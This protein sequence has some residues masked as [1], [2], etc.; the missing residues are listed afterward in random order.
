MLASYGLFIA[1]VIIIVSA[2]EK[3]YLCHTNEFWIYDAL[4][5]IVLLGFIYAAKIISNIINAEMEAAMMIESQ[6]SGL[7]LARI[8]SEARKTSMRNMWIV[9]LTL[10][11]CT[12]Y[13]TLYTMGVYFFS[14]DYC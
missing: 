9:C 4:L 6:D 1:E 8:I 3:D 2:G 10:T 12:F 5:L 14:G 7:S 11:F 13:D